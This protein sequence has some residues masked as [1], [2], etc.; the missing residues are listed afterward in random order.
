MAE[1]ALSSR[2]PLDGTIGPVGG[3]HDAGVVLRE[4]RLPGLLNLRGDATDKGFLAAVSKAVG[5][6]PPVAPNTVVEG[7]AGV[8]LWLGPD[9]WLIVTP[10]GDET[11]IAAA[12]EKALAGVHT[13]VVDLSDSYATLRLSG[14]K[15]R[16]VLSKGWPVDLHPRAFGPGHCAQSHLAHANVILRQLDDTPSY[17]LIVRRSFARYLWDWLL[18]ASLEV[19]CRIETA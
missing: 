5:A 7:K 6:E 14:A 2:T 12:L 19:G 9:E 11:K 4:E 10:A 16:W 15:A 18:D 8:V 13:S 1:P 17:Q 3:P